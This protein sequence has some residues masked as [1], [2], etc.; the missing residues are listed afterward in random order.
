MFTYNLV[1]ADVLT[2]LFRTD[3]SVSSREHKD[4]RKLN[5]PV[6]SFIL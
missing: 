5:A 2:S 1:P 3:L 4:A 6:T